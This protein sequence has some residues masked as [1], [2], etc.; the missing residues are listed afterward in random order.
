MNIILFG[1]PGAG[2]GTQCSHVADKYGLYKL[3]TGDMIRQEIKNQ[4]DI[5]KKVK[6]IV[7]SGE[8]PSSD[9][10]NE[11][12]GTTIDQHKKGKGFV[13]DGYPRTLVQGQF[14]DA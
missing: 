11:M 4:T 1:P 2:K 9:M 10:F 13:F 14:L 6:A 5:G 7:E 3:S 12:V 8:L